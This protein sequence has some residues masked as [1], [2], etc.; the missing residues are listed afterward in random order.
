MQFPVVSVI[1][2]PTLVPSP[3]HIFFLFLPPLPS[4]F[5]AKEYSLME[6]EYHSLLC[7]WMK[8][9]FKPKGCSRQF[10]MTHDLVYPQRS[11]EKQDASS[12]LQ[13]LEQSKPFINVIKL[14]DDKKSPEE[15]PGTAKF[16]N[17]RLITSTMAREEK[18]FVNQASEG[19]KCSTQNIGKL[20]S[21]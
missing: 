5:V 6:A 13:L 20:E 12:F 17:S 2:C 14:P 9:G 11:L 21:H 10:S 8:L 4:L 16:P 7:R 18:L 19:L 1:Q 3:V 15:P